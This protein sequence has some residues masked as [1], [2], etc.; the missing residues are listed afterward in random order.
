MPVCT[1]VVSF[2]P[3]EPVPLLLLGFRDELAAR[4]WKPP[5]RHWPGSPLVGGFDEQAGGTW[6]AVHPGI[7][8]VSCILNGRGG[9]APQASRRS[10]GEL[11]LLAA[12]KGRE[13]LA[14]LHEDRERLA[15][16]DP[17]HLV[18]ADVTEVTLLSWDGH[19]ATLTELAPG[20]HMITNA[21]LTPDD[22]KVRHFGARFA[23]DRPSGAPGVP[24]AQAWHP[25]L[26]LA[27]G[28]G[29]PVGDP[30]AIR[31][32]KTLPDGRVWGTTSISLVALGQAA[33]LRY[34]FQALPD[35]TAPR[36]VG[37]LPA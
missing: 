21:G 23:A 37:E 24:V 33:G 16:Y 9:Q 31:A 18:H 14:S 32:H 29:L 11:P 35:E 28:D 26:K 1:V 25:W 2:V 4:P 10:R 34:D 22:P 6:L 19:A 30:R 8:R 7:A 20:T 12:D 3:R 15:A 13:A 36:P 5:A 27:E 17:F